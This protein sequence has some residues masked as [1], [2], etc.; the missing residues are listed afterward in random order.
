MTPVKIADRKK[1]AA[2]NGRIAAFS[3]DHEFARDED[4]PKRIVTAPEM[5]L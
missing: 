2:D 4:L 1:D 5:G 3:Y